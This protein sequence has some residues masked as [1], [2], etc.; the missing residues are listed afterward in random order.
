ARAPTR[1]R[2]CSCRASAPRVPCARAALGARDAHAVE[3]HL[4]QQQLALDAQRI[5]RQVL[6]GLGRR[7]RH[8]LALRREYA[9]VARAE[10]ALVLRLEAHLATE[11]RTGAG[12]R[13]E[14]LGRVAGS[15]A[16][17]ADAIA[18]RRAV[19]ERGALRKATEHRE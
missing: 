12:E 7:T 4:D 19:V 13:D 15:D 8:G 6:A 11:V 18:G 9:V 3:R 1:Q 16:R 14:V 10:E 17:H 2:A 5:A